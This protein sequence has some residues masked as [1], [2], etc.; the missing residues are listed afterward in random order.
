MVAIVIIIMVLIVAAIVVVQS[1]VNKG[2]YRAKQTVLGGAG[3]DHQSTCDKVVSG[4][5]H[6]K[7]LP[8]MQAD[9]PY[10]SA[11]MVESRFAYVVN[12]VMTGTHVAGVPSYMIDKVRSNGKFSHLKNGT[13]TKTGI[14][15][16]RQGAVYAQSVFIEGT[17]QWILYIRGNFDQAGN[18]TVTQ[19]QI[20]K[21]IQGGF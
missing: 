17:D 6:S 21:G 20:S 16:Y 2:V 11:E 8:Q 19:L 18:L 7:G 13:Y 3:L 1:F 4:P 12:A 14:I 15:N 5:L 10:A 9:N